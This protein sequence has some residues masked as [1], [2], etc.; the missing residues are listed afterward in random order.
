[1]NLYLILYSY[2]GETKKTDIVAQTRE[3]AISEFYDTHSKQCLIQEVRLINYYSY[4][5]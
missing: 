5:K 3:I 2:K 4:N 1:M